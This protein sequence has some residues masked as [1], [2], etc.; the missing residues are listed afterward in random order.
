LRV[1]VATMG[2]AAGSNASQRKIHAWR[3]QAH[4]GHDH[5]QLARLGERLD[6]AR[7]RA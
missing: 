2:L 1:V 3:G 6:D 5:A 7:A 4:G